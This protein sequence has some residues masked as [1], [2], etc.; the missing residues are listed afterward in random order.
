V[1]RKAGRRADDGT[2]ASRHTRS[3][4]RRWGQPV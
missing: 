1:D 3:P 4:N 2:P